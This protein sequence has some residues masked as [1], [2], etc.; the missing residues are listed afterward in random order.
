MANEHLR[1]GAL[2]KRTGVSVRTLHHYDEIGLLEPSV[3]GR[4]E[5]RFYGPPEIERLQ[6]I[7]SLRQLGF[8]LDEIQ[9]CLDDPAFAPAPLVELHLA[10]IDDEIALLDDLRRRLRAVAER[11]PTSPAASTETLLEAIEGI[12][13]VHDF[14]KHYTPRQREVLEERRAEVGEERIAQVKAEWEHLFDAFRAA[15]DD[16]HGPDAPP[17]RVLARRAN[18]L[19]AEFTGGDAGIRR[20]LGRMHAERPE[21]RAGFGVDEAVWRYM[22]EAMAELPSA[23]DG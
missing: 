13:R 6:R 5:A 7:L 11:L 21:I 14:A 3:G 16:G 22:Q 15:L 10:R 23:N 2:A 12:A 17:V 20:S 9:G 4:G 8:S 18:A 19:I 1:I